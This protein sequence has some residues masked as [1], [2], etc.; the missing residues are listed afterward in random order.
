MIFLQDNRFLDQN[1]DTSRMQY[2]I[3]TVLTEPAARF[4]QNVSVEPSKQM[5]PFMH[6]FQRGAGKS[7][8]SEISIIGIYVFMEGHTSPIIRSV[9]GLHYVPMKVEIGSGS[10]D[11]DLFRKNFLDSIF[12]IN[13]YDPLLP[14]SIH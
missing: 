13:L 9:Q 4:S 7:T 8:E 14:T 10:T 2:A 1:G 12:R 5:L 11:P 3:K 6:M